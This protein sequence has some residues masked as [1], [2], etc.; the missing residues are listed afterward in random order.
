MNELSP[1]I[2]ERY[3]ILDT[4]A[5]SQC[6]VYK[7][8][9]TKLGR[10][11]AIKTPDAKVLANQEKLQSFVEEGRKLASIDNI[12]ILPVLHFYDIGEIDNSCYIIT[13]WMELTLQDILETEKL[14]L[15]SS[16]GIL[17]KILQGVK[18]LHNADIIH[19]D[20]KPSNIFVSKDA[21]SVKIGDLGIAANIGEDST[22]TK[23]GFTPKYFAPET[24]DTTVEIDRRSDIY[25]AG[26]LAYELILGKDKFRSVFSD[27]YQAGD[28]NS[29]N[30]RWTNWHRDTN[31]TAPSLRDLFPDVPDNVSNVVSK[32]MSKDPS[33]RQSDIDTI[34]NELNT[35]ASFSQQSQGTPFD[36]IDPVI[37]GSK[38]S[39]AKPNLKKFLIYC[40]SILGICLLAL[41]LLFL[42]PS[43]KGNKEE[44]TKAGNQMKEIRA[45]A[46]EI[47]ANKYAGKNSFEN[48]DKNREKGIKDYKEKDFE[49]A[50]EIFLK[51]KDNF[52]ESIS[53]HKEEIV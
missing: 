2:K 23:D 51:A 3:E 47:E 13:P 32:M 34:L 50:L 31:R 53:L 42:F 43:S 25:S 8:K 18:A 41:S 4:T 19:R 5:G 14:S 22:L 28:V 9:D 29:R 46:L 39:K 17:T 35:T 27:I 52:S 38:T 30:I 11:V 49:S 6:I 44:A 15:D 21:S 26:M 10:T 20:I 12:G 40:F 16:L 36:I 48:G 7:A 1:A 37:P 33:S 24:S 45:I